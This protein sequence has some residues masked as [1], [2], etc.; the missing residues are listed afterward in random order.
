[1]TISAPWVNEPTPSRLSD[2]QKHTAK[3]PESVASAGNSLALYQ[4]AVHVDPTNHEAVSAVATQLLEEAWFIGR[5]LLNDDPNNA[6]GAT[7]VAGMAVTFGASLLQLRQ[8]QRAITQVLQ[9]A[10]DTGTHWLAKMPGDR[11]R[12]YILSL[13]HMWAADCHEDLRA[14]TRLGLLR[15]GASQPAYSPV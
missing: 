8:P 3:F 4:R 14:Y 5:S 10:I 13:L 11:A 6:Q 12:T 9:A 7:D 1:M 2:I 15:N